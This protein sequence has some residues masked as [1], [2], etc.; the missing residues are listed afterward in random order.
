[1]TKAKFPDS[2]HL[3]NELINQLRPQRQF[4][5]LF[6]PRLIAHQG[7]EIVRPRY[8][9]VP[10][11][12]PHDHPVLIAMRDNNEV[13]SAFLVLERRQDRRKQRVEACRWNELRLLYRE[14]H[15]GRGRFLRELEIISFGQPAV[16]VVDNE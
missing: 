14:R 11:E 13:R 15:L 16:V 12:K 8:F 2:L 5:R 6:V 3:R 9:W 10:M 1:M 4:L 7:D